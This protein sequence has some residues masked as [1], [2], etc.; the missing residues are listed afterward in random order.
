MSTTQ[1]MIDILGVRVTDPGHNEFF[2][3]VK[4]EALEFGQLIVSLLFVD[5]AMVEL[6][7]TVDRTSVNR[8]TN[9][10]IIGSDSFIYSP[11]DLLRYTNTKHNDIWSTR[12]DQADIKITENV[13]SRPVASNPI[14]Y[15]LSDHIYSMDGNVVNSYDEQLQYIRRPGRLLVDQG[16]YTTFSAGGSTPAGGSYV[17]IPSGDLPITSPVE[18]IGCA[19]YDSI[20]GDNI[21]GRLGIIYH[22]EN[23]LSNTH[24][25][26]SPA[27]NSSFTATMTIGPCELNESHH[28]I[29]VTIAE[30]FLYW[31][32]GDYKKYLD[33]MNDSIVKIIGINTVFNAT[34]ADNINMD[35]LGGT[36]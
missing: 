18:L 29:V 31:I 30:A 33:T 7:D 15:L 34:Y 13:F 21:S 20:F 5:N 14:T 35:T 9:P 26:I 27:A 22:A 23:V 28:D 8:T 3:A 10:P 16:I 24:V 19:V 1:D 25:F 4:L 6:G 2:P 32:R 17:S 12:L 11:V 36:S